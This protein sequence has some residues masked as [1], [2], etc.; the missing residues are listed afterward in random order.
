M[1][2]LLEQ[3]LQRDIECGDHATAT[4]RALEH[5][6]PE[7]RRWQRH[8]LD[9]DADVDDAFSSFSVDLWRSF[10]TFR[11]ACSV[12]T[13]CFRLGANAARRHRQ[14]KAQGRE[15]GVS[16]LDQIPAT[17][18]RQDTAPWLKT[19]YKDRFALLRS[20][21]SKEEQDLLV[22]RIDQRMGWRDIAIIL[23]DSEAL[24]DAQLNA[25]AASLRKRFQRLKDRIRKSVADDTE[26]AP[27]RS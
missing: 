23:A 14:R 1:S 12:R 24:S 2:E 3:Q 11:G 10:R 21:L 6:G 7:V 4:R 15:V 13:W 20:S 8:L 16:Q 25:S 5:Y 9:T 27:T 19:E 22:L 26:G 18:G 17:E